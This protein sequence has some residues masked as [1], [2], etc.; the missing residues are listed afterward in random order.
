MPPPGANRVKSTA[1]LKYI[2]YTN[3]RL[4]T[5]S[6]VGQLTRIKSGNVTS[7][8]D[9]HQSWTCHAHAWFETLFKGKVIF[10][11]SNQFKLAILYLKKYFSRKR[12]LFISSTPARRHK[13]EIF[14]ST[15]STF[16][17]FDQQKHL[18]RLFSCMRGQKSQT[19]QRWRVPTKW[20]HCPIALAHR[21]IVGKHKYK[22]NINLMET[23][24]LQ[25]RKRSD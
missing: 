14:P 22:K 17:P 20:R 7:R 6:N 12:W 23:Q 3:Y 18:R 10:Y 15:K 8:H 24:R 4:L 2:W 1:L 19:G 5:S 21:M 13:P 25:N 11:A 9:M 16:F